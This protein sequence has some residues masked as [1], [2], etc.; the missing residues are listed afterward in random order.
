MKITRVETIR[1]DKF[2]NLLWLRLHTDEGVIGLGE[3][4]FGARAAEGGSA[5]NLLLGGVHPDTGE[6]YTH[7][8]LDGGGWGGRR[9][10]DGNSA[11]C[12]AHASSIR[13]TP[14]RYSKADFPYARWNTACAPIRAAPAPGA[15]CL[16]SAGYSR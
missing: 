6:F 2:S 14:M 11:Q 4:F 16:V 12:P 15:V 13:A 5:C 3:T 1:L 10:M 7:Y 8:Q 9:L